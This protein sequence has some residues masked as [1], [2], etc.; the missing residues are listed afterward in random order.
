MLYVCLNEFS[1]CITLI[2]LKCMT[3]CIC[4]YLNEFSLLFHPQTLLSVCGSL[5]V[6]FLLQADFHYPVLNNRGGAYQR[7]VLSYRD[8]A[9]NRFLFLCLLSL[10]L[11]FQD[12]YPHCQDDGRSDLGPVKA[13]TG[14]QDKFVYHSENSVGF[15][16]FCNHPLQRR[17]QPGW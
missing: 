8:L 16:R 14:K 7:L 1:L 11:C 13:N 12:T 4:I 5:P 2:D 6:C 9:P 15:L 3:M 17:R 10:Y